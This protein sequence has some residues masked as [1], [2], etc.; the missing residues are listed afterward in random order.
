MECLDRLS[1]EEK[2][3]PDRVGSEPVSVPGQGSAFWSVANDR[4][5]HDSPELQ[6][7]GVYQPF[8]ELATFSIKM[9]SVPWDL[10]GA[11]YA[12]SA[13][14]VSVRCAD[15]APGPRPDSDHDGPVVA[16]SVL[17]PGSF[18]AQ[19]QS[20][21]GDANDSD[22]P[23]TAGGWLSTPPLPTSGA[24]TDCLVSVRQALR[25]RV[26]QQQQWSASVAQPRVP[27][28]LFTMPAGRSGTSGAR[29]MGWIHHIP[30]FPRLPIFFCPSGMMA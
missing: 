20:S 10:F 12:F 18:G 9:L 6:A 16:E 17:V 3:C 26:F 2:S 24:H 1:V 19:H 23:D 21:S 22:T 14:S 15:E 27:P 11:A 7:G 8:S 29:D 28:L 4:S 25:A 13:H 30:L 5:A